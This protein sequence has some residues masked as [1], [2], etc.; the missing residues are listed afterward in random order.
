MAEAQSR[1]RFTVINGG[2]GGGPA[3]ELLRVLAEAGVPQE[4]LDGLDG[5]TDPDQVIEHLAAAGVLPEPGDAVAGLISGFAP[6]TERGIGALE[7]EIS[8]YEFLAA[9]RAAP[10]APTGDD[11]IEMLIALAGQVETH[12]GPAALAMLRLLAVTGPKRARPAAAQAADR[13]VAGG[14]RDRPWVKDLGRPVVGTPAF[15]YGD[16]LGSQETVAVT[17]RYGRRDHA[18]AVLIDHHLGGGVKDIWAA[19][20]P[21]V[22]RDGFRSASGQGGIVFRDYTPAEAAAILRRALDRP[23]CPEQPDQ[24]ADVEVFLDLLR[25]RVELLPPSPRADVRRLR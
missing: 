25:G 19:S 13:M 20:E 8:A 24:V 3:A 12:G 16:D 15:G 17:F 21:E 6:L 7:A 23:A 22:L 11:E 10:H 9:M 2:G 1:P 18:V 4:V 14:L 5:V